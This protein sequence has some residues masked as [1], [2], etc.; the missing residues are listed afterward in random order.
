MGI[1]VKKKEGE[2]PASL[3]SRFIK[4]VQR[5]G[6][7]FEVKRRS[8]SRR[9]PNKRSRRLSTLYK[10]KKTAEVEKAKKEGLM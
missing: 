7:F 10:V 8:F 5:T 3:I 1:E 6:L 4:K 9:N 2:S